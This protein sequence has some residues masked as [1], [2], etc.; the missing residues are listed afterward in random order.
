MHVSNH[1][2]IHKLLLWNYITE[3]VTII[4]FC[5]LGKGQVKNVSAHRYNFRTHLATGSE[6]TKQDTRTS[7]SKYGYVLL[8]CW[9]TLYIIFQTERACYKGKIVE[10]SPNWLYHSRKWKNNAC[11][12]ESFCLLR[13]SLS[14]QFLSLQCCFSR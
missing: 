10:R 7:T 14:C 4:K 6:L 5:S 11:I 9:V 1:F 8:T 2:I 13:K 3:A 12:P